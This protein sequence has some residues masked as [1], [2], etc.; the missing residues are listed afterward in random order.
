MNAFPPICWYVQMLNSL[1]GVPF[2]MFVIFSPSSSETKDNYTIWFF[3]SSKSLAPF[4][5]YVRLSGKN[6]SQLYSERKNI[7]KIKENS[8]QKGE[9]SCMRKIIKRI[10]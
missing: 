7:A 4:H 2:N 10:F 9:N 1:E 5:E 3:L 8:E 6:K